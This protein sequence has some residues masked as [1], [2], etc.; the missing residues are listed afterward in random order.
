M[1]SNSVDQLNAW[2]ALSIKAQKTFSAVPNGSN[3]VG[4]RRGFNLAA[5]AL[6]CLRLQHAKTGDVFCAQHA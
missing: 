1:D 5:W 4:E 6:N 3:K 2:L